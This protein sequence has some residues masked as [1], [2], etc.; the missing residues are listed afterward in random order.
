MWLLLVRSMG[1]I[2]AFEKNAYKMP[3]LKLWYLVHNFLTYLAMLLLCAFPRGLYSLVLIF[4]RYQVY[5]L[6]IFSK[7]K[8][9][10]VVNKWYK[11]M[12]YLYSTCA[13]VRV[14]G[15]GMDTGQP[16]WRKTR[17]GVSVEPC[18]C[19]CVAFGTA[20]LLNGLSGVCNEAK[21]KVHRL[22]TDDSTNGAGEHR[23]NRYVCIISF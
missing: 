19:V 22:T 8:T 4:V 10:L 14:P 18:P 3:T 12:K 16:V 11:L 1:L 20:L 5:S 15:Y 9:S 21:I 6:H 17:R 2:V 13:V 23:T 7:S